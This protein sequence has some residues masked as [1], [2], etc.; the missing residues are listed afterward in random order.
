MRDP[1]TTLQV[2]SRDSGYPGDEWYLEFHKRHFPGGLRF[3]RVT[4]PKSDL[5]DKQMYVPERAEERT[6]AHAA[7]F[8]QVVRGVLARYADETGQAGVLCSPFDTELFG[9]WWAEGP[10]L[11]RARVPRPPGRRASPPPPRARTWRIG[12]RTGRSR[13]SKA[14]GAKEETI[15]SG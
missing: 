5:A 9:H 8:T 15:G 1:E 13:S 11:A 10:L 12:P 14:R 6:R 4:H 2:W 3:W 7:H